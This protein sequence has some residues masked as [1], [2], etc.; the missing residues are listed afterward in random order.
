MKDLTLLVREQDVVMSKSRD[1]SFERSARRVLFSVPGLRKLWLR[2]V[3]GR[4][5]VDKFEGWGMTTDT[6]PPW[7]GEQDQIARDFLAAHVKWYMPFGMDPSNSPSSTPLTTKTS[8]S[9]ASCG[10]TT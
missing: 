2:W 10:V 1:L 5:G 6:I 4:R 3:F 7:Q 8:Y 9:R